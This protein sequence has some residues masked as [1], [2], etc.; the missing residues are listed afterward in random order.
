MPSPPGLVS[1]TTGWPSSCASGCVKMRAPSSA[2]PPGGKGTM[3]RIGLLGYCA[4]AAAD[5]SA[6]T[7]PSTKRLPMVTPPRRR[8]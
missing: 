2:A 3:K 8:F 4:A 6:R 1:T 5:D 7:T